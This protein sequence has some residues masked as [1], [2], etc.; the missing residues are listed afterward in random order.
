MRL[1]TLKR[2]RKG[3][4]MVEAAIILPVF[5]LLVFG[6]IEA[7]RLGMVVQILTTASREGCRVAVIDGNN[8]SSTVQSAVNGILTNASMPTQTLTVS[9]S[10][11]GSTGAYLMPSTWSTSSGG[12]AITLTLRLPYNSLSW[13]GTP[14]LFRNTSVTASA[15]MASE[16]P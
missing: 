13:F 11:P 9:D 2:K 3:A 16:R 14:F 5:L 8:D 1:R 7:S 6:L 10:D 15:T 4:A 12:T